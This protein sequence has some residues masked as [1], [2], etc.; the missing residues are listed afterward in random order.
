MNQAELSGNSVP[1]DP[2]LAELIAVWPTLPEATRQT[3]LAL[4][5]EVKLSRQ[6]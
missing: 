5:G 4:I 6:R 2:V 1:I 3:V